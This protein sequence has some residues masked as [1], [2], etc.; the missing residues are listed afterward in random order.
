MLSR[1]RSRR[2]ESVLTQSTAPPSYESRPSSPTE[3]DS[4]PIPSY[5][6][7][8]SNSTP[9]SLH[10][11][12]SYTASSNST[13]QSSLP[14]PLPAPVTLSWDRNSDPTFR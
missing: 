12:P 3:P 2:P 10:S 4:E 6:T 5:T 11:T 7:N 14:L 9:S 8:S 1:S 13:S